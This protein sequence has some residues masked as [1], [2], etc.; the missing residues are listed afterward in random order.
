M[1]ETEVVL[2]TATDEFTKDKI[3]NKVPVFKEEL[4]LATEKQISRN[5]FYSAGQNEI[6]ISKQ[7]IVHPFEYSNQKTLKIEGALYSVV[8]SYKLNNEEL[9]LILKVKAG[10]KS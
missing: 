8:R 4:I 7:I 3:G 1:W 9:E 10:N 6:E 2:L 5:E